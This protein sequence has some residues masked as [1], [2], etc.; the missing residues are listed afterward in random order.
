MA[1]NQWGDEIIVPAQA[2][3]PASTP[4]PAA[5][6]LNQWG[7]EI[8][9]PAP[10]MG[11]M[12][13]VKD[14]FTGESRQDPAYK[15][16]PEFMQ[17][18][19]GQPKGPNG[20]LPTADPGATMRSAI[21]PTEAGQLDILR[22][23]IPGLEEQRDAKGNLMLRAPGM[24][25]WAYLNKPG[26]SV[27][28]VDELG[29]QTLATLPFMGV[30]GAGGGIAARTAM[31]AGGM[32]AGSVAQDAMA[33]AAGSEQGIDP[34]RAA[35]SGAVGAAIPG[36]VEP[37]VKTVGTI[38]KAAFNYPFNRIRS[39][40][41]PEAQATRDVQAALTADRTN[42]RGVPL[43]AAEVRQAGRAGQDPRVVDLGGEN[44]RALARSAANQ[45]PSA[46]AAIENLADDRLEGQAGRMETFIR[47]LVQRPG[48]PGG[49]N[50]FATREALET[51]ARGARKPLYDAAYGQGATGMMS[52]V[53]T[54]LQEAPAM[55]S[56]MRAAAGIMQN[57]AAAGKTT[58]LRGPN[59]FT[60][61]YW[62]MVKR[63]LDDQVSTFKR[64]GAKSA[65]MDI[66]NLR[67]PLVAELDR[68][69]PDFAKA[70]GTAQTFFKA[71]DALEA[72]E[73]YVN[74][75]FNSE[76]TRKALASMTPQERDL[77]A[78]GFASR[79]MQQARRVGDR[80][81]LLNS[82]NNSPDAR[83][84]FTIALGPNR[85]RSMEAFL[86]VEG[87]L[88][89]LRKAQ[90]NSTTARQLVEL[91]LIGASGYHAYETEPSAILGAILVM[92]NR[93]I[94]RR[95]AERVAQQLLSPNVTQMMAGLKQVG[96]TP[97]MDALRSFDKLM[98][99]TGIASQGAREA[100]PA[101][102]APAPTPSTPPLPE[103]KSAPTGR[104]AALQGLQEAQRM[105][106]EAIAR[107]AQEDA[108]NARL[109]AYIKAN[110]LTDGA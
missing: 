65:A 87:V 18:Q 64:Q 20:E 3:A 43:N 81:S 26:F 12:A 68:M 94:N 28:D 42:P 102:P 84:R 15:D 19:L 76:A 79:F 75:R 108:V 57:R 40:V 32:A 6:K 100:A 96:S 80:R 21:A 1:T 5:P 47:D 90:G 34:V 109:A 52:P 66:D 61:E 107:G 30:A 73:N 4:A 99:R 60:L 93:H 77:F 49:P 8:I 58:G 72:G 51:A 50:A 82:I 36:I 10:K 88:D 91:G 106:Q 25:E 27:R 13:R 23:N 105:A 98:V 14:A 103:R 74:G 7:D 22:K 9:V 59:G 92:G 35:V 78:E 104:G 16:A 41:N 29:T 95:V 31:G 38:A 110:N 62:D 11:F 45:S 53:L 71:S 69:V 63:H 86:R 56:A 67:R 89:L 24:K 85:A 83:E 55:E 54:K 46:R 48:Q 70:R 17:A 39:A 44:T 97:M 33:T 37:V 2:A 101:Q